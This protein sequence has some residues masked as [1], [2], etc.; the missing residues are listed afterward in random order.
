MDVQILNVINETKTLTTKLI[1]KSLKVIRKLLR[2]KQMMSNLRKLLRIL[3]SKLKKEMILQHLENY[4]REGRIIPVR[5]HQCNIGVRWSR[6]N[7]NHS[8]EQ[9]KIQMMLLIKYLSQLVM[10]HSQ[11]YF[12]NVGIYYTICIICNCHVKY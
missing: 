6:T 10:K 12:Q 2:R 8:G 11:H 5:D 7:S 3:R 9:Q 4:N 1:E